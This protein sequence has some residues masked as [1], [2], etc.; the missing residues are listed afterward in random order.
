VDF[1][2]DDCRLAIEAKA[3]ARVQADH[4]RG[5]RELAA[6]QRVRR[7]VVVSLDARSRR[8]EDGIDIL[9]AHVFARRLWAGEVVEG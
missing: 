4:L 2:D 6:D 9:P 5:L 7:R 1:V 8:T 3:T